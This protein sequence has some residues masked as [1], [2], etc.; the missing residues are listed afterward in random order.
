MKIN[1]QVILLIMLI[2]ILPL[3]FAGTYVALNGTAVI[4]SKIY[5]ITFG[6]FYLIAVPI[7]AIMIIYYY[8]NVDK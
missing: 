8:K 2:S 1:K 4:R 3:I 6:I 7:G 5:L